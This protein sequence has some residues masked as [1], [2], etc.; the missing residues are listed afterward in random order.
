MAPQ[1]VGQG[2]ADDAVALGREVAVL[3]EEQR[4]RVAGPGHG[5]PQVQVGDAYLQAVATEAQ[6]RAVTDFLDGLEVQLNS[7]HMALSLVRLRE[8]P[9]SAEAAA[10]IAVDELAQWRPEASERTTTLPCERVETT[11]RFTLDAQPIQGATAVGDCGGGVALDLPPRELR[12]AW[13]RA[14]GLDP[15]AGNGVV[16]GSVQLRASPGAMVSALEQ[17]GTVNAAIVDRP[18]PLWGVVEELARTGGN[19]LRPFSRDVSFRIEVGGLDTRPWTWS[20]LVGFIFGLAGAAAAARMLVRVQANRAYQAVWDRA[21]GADEDPLRQ[22]PVAVVL[23]EAQEEVRKRW[24]SR[25]LG[26]GVLALLIGFGLAYLLL[27]LA[28][29]RVTLG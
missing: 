27:R 22:R 6:H 29:L 7:D 1:E 26:S 15:F 4:R 14:H 13:A 12:A 2:L 8:P 9:E 16:E 28:L 21:V 23:A 18:L 11:A 5:H 19:G 17:L 3:G 20:L 25:W 24:L 10:T